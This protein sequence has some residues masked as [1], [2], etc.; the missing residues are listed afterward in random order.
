M[1]IVIIRQ[2]ARD[3]DHWWTIIHNRYTFLRSY[4]LLS[5][6]MHVLV[7][8]GG[9]RDMAEDSMRMNS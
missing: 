6:S 4:L 3:N 8:G 7:K 2:I 1:D 5:N 9:G